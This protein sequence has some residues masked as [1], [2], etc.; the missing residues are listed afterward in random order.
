MRGEIID[1][2]QKLKIK[3]RFGAGFGL[4]QLSE[5]YCWQD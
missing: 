1:E 5:R 4:T 2:Y 3:K